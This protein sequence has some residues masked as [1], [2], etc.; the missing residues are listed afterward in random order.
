M[1]GT[2]LRAAFLGLAAMAALPPSPALAISGGHP[3]TGREF[4]FV[5][6]LKIQWPGGEGGICTG[7]LISD[8]LVLTA[9]HCV[10]TVKGEPAVGM[11]VVRKP[12]DTK[13]IPASS[14]FIHSGYRQ[15]SGQ[16][17]MYY[18]VNDLAILVLRDRADGPYAQT[19]G[20]YLWNTRGRVEI[21]PN[22]SLTA[23]KPPSSEPNASLASAAASLDPKAAFLGRLG[24]DDARKMMD[25]VLLRDESGRPYAVQ[26]GFGR[27]ACDR[28]SGEC[29]SVPSKPKYIQ[30]YIF[31][32]RTDQSLV[33]SWCDPAPFSFF[34]KADNLICSNDNAETTRSPTEHGPNGIYGAQ[35]GDSGGPAV[36]FDKDNRAFIIGTMSYGSATL[37]VNMNLVEHMD[38]LGDVEKG[39]GPRLKSYPLKLPQVRLRSSAGLAPQ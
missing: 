11:D 39:S 2:S 32:Y 18:T 35:P 27:F 14:F 21:D 26:I 22:A 4:G 24:P 1:I 15:Q 13:G 3:A 6:L 31:N 19:P 34:A 7:S 16:G 5:R 33:T 17:V 20:D 37:A 25:Q 29:Q 9:A 10:M 36:A 30:K 23:P 12:S 28:R 8:R 38:F